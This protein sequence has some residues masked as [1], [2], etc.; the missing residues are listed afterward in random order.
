[1]ST[2]N[3][4]TPIADFNIFSGFLQNSLIWGGFRRKPGF[5]IELSLCQVSI[6]RRL[7][8]QIQDYFGTRAGHSDGR[9]RVHMV[10]IRRGEETNC[11]VIPLHTSGELFRG[12]R[13]IVERMPPSTDERPIDLK[14]YCAEVQRLF[15][16]E[17][18]TH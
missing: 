6:Q 8:P 10:E 13:Q 16:S 1:M 9:K 3:L 17:V 4:E 11:L 7:Q 12:L 5:S 14:P 18:W 2:S 15:A